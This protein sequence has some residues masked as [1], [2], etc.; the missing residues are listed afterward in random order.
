MVIL[1]THCRE[2]A[3]D[4][5]EKCNSPGTGEIRGPKKTKNS[6]NEASMLLK[7]KKGTSETKLKRTQNEPQLSAQM[8]DIEPKFEL[9]DTAHVPAGDWIVGDAAGNEIARLGETRGNCER[10]QK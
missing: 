9:F 10:I 2:Q 6:T 7:T 5:E 1:W 4:R 8:R 3:S